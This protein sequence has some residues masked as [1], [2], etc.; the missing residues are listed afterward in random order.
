[1][2]SFVCKNIESFFM[3]TYKLIEDNYVL[4]NQPKLIDSLGRTGA[5]FLCQIHYWI[6]QGCGTIHEGIQ[7]I[8]NTEKEWGKQ[9]RLSERQIRHYI[10]KLS[11]MGI[12]S[13]KKLQKKRY[14]RTNHITINYDVLNK[15][16]TLQNQ[17][18]LHEE[19]TASSKRKKLPHV[20][21]KITN[22][23]KN[24]KSKEGKGDFEN[25]KDNTN[26]Q[27]KN[28]NLNEKKLD[29]SSSFSETNAK[30]TNQSS[31]EK[32]TTIQ[33]MITIWNESF[34]KAQT[35]LNKDLAKLMGGAFKQKFG[36][37]LTL[38][39][40][41]CKRIESSSYL[42]GEGFKLSLYWALKFTTIDRILNGELG[43]KDIA[44][45]IVEEDLIQ[46]AKVHIESIDETPLCVDVR[47]KLLKVIGA[48][49]YL[50]WFTRVTFVE[51]GGEVTMKAETPF[52]EDYIKTHFGHLFVIAQ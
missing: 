45:P 18:Q 31:S 52:V 35:R 9:I 10:K 3:H 39:K 34:P 7:W 16:V 46:K 32:P 30:K 40:N 43:V 14:D 4:L 48:A 51:K 20:Y 11:E 47:E 49:S 27:V 17:A 44:I 21:T 1:M 28:I 42:M 37:N 38:W 15:L 33:D 24:Y 26:K 23:D 6:E 50:S 29:T 41:Y 12:L 8:Y 22:K 13:V 25:K 2:S 36:S 5:Q 19:E